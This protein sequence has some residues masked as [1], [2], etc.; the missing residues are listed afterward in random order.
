MTVF[1]PVSILKEKK[2][3]AIKKANIIFNAVFQSLWLTLNNLMK[4]ISL[5]VIINIIAN[6]F[7]EVV[8]SF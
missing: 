4:F 3:K 6:N 2:E 7:L 5:F 8:G 1:F